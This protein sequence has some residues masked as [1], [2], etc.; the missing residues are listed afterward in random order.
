MLFTSIKTTAFLI[1]QEQY[2]LDDVMGY[3]LWLHGFSFTG[4]HSSHTHTHTRNSYTLIHITITRFK[5][6]ARGPDP[7]RSNAM[8][9]VSLSV[10]FLYRTRFSVN[11]C[12]CRL[13]QFILFGE[14]AEEFRQT[15]KVI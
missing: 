4:I 11:R 14:C 6:V 7:F 2:V 3:S 13:P 9:S 15:R 5:N 12:M 1:S 10:Y 8:L